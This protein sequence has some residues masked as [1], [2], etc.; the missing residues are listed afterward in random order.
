[1][2]VLYIEE[3]R[4]LKVK[5]TKTVSFHRLPNSNL[6]FQMPLYGLIIK[7]KYPLRIPLF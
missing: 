5:Q 6:T 4:C 7:Q 3:A 1:M 2:P